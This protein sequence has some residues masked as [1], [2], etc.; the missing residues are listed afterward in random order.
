MTG[1]GSNAKQV[2]WHSCLLVLLLL[3]APPGYC[4]RPGQGAKPGQHMLFV[5]PGHELARPSDAARVARDGALVEIVAGDYKGDVA[6]WRQ[7]DL[8]LRGVGPR[9]H[10]RAGGRSAEGKAIWVIKGDRVTVEN[11]ELSGAKVP[12]HNGAGIRAEGSGLTIRGCRFHHNEMGLLTNPSPSSVVV[13]EDSEFDHNRTDTS[14][15]G[16]LGHN[17]YIHRISRFVLRNSQVHGAETGHQVK[18]RARRNEIRG[19]RIRDADGASSFLLDISEGGDA[20]VTGN[21]FEQSARASNRTAIA[22]AGEAGN[23][24][25]GHSLRVLRNH[26]LNRGGSATFVRNHSSAQVLLQSNQI[27]GRGVTP[28]RGPGSVE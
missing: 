15:H 2:R 23:R 9:P 12:S 11:I 28:L 3:A 13:I 16:K 25:S 24:S 1:S 17:I 26:F 8:T 7:D 20:Q 14:R 19:N 27:E 22:F 5:G 18:T 6:V 10:L 21:R 4:S